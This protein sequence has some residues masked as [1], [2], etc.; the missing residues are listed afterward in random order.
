LSGEP[1]GLAVDAAGVLHWAAPVAGSYAF[2]ATATTGLGLSASAR[3]TLSVV[4]VNHAPT[5]PSGIVAVPPGVP[6]RLAL[7]GVDV[8]GDALTYTMTGAPRGLV[9]SS[10]GVLS[11]PLTQRGRWVLHVVARDAQG[12]AS[13]PA[14]IVLNVSN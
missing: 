7:S 11:W 2:T 3:Y 9:L 12:L 10:A 6:L 1:E 5:L 4:K 14:A 13:A 8:D